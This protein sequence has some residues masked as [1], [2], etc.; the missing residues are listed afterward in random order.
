MVKLV[1]ADHDRYVASVL[2]HPADIAAARQLHATVYKE[3]GWAGPIDLTDSGVLND[4]F[5][6][7]HPLAVYFGV[8]DLH[9][10]SDQLVV[11]GRMLD[12]GSLGATALQTAAECDILPELREELESS[13]PGTVVEIS[14]LAKAMR[15]NP[16]ATLHLYR[17]MGVYS[18]RAGHRH[19]IMACD[20]TLSRKL[21]RLFGSSIDIVG[22]PSFLLGSTV[23]PMHSRIPEYFD[24]LINPS[25]EE[26][27]RTFTR[28]REF[29]AFLLERTPA[30][31]LT[32]EGLLRRQL[33]EP[34][35]S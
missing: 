26:D 17:E 11:S 29:A 6:P 34:R 5:D 10:G 18:L 30:E 3:K 22:H 33:P 14:G 16:T 21:S 8:K 20:V 28:R 32:P 27:P 7:W 4:A 13:P 24:R 19:W 15:A 12:P 2:L 23:V 9:S 31:F 25:E 35:G 1:S